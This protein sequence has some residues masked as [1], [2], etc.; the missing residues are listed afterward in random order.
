MF[1]HEP[2]YY[3]CPFCRIIAGHEDGYA[4]KQDVI[5]EN[6]YV[7]AK[8]APKWWINKSGECIGST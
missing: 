3:D 1:S 5:Y 8:I 2:E 6:D 4:T 7:T